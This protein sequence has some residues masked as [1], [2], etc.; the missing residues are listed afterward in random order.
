MKND[1]VDRREFIKTSGSAAAGMMVTAV[2]PSSG[3][4]TSDSRVKRTLKFSVIGVNHDHIY[5]Q[6]E[7]ARRGGGELV[8]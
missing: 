3:L 2:L 1:P 7:A 8:S 4:I 6:V 5:A